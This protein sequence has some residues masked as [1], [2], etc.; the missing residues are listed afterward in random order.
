[1]QIIHDADMGTHLWYKLGG[2]AKYLLIASSR[3]DVQE[4]LDF[5]TENKIEK[6]F[7]CG[8][9]ANLIFTDDYFDGAVLQIRTGN[10]RLYDEI[11]LSRKVP[12]AHIKKSDTTLTVFG[13]EILDNL[14]V[15]SLQHNLTGLEWAG[16][17]PGTVGAGIRGNVGCFGGE[18]KDSVVDVEVIDFS[19]KDFQ[20]KKL[21]REELNFSYR[22]SLVKLHSNMI[23]L[24]ATF[25]LHNGING[26]LEKAKQTYFGNI[27]Y[28]KTR[29][30]L[31][32]PNCGSVFKN[33][34]KKDEVAKVLEVWPDA[35]EKIE[36]K[37]YGKVAMGY[38]I[39]KLGFAGETVGKAQIS[40]KHGNYILNLGG[41][42]AKDVTTL[43]H[44][45]QEKCQKTFGFTPEVEVEIIK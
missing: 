26:E 11:S 40:E 38:I 41:A 16:G 22:S 2:K 15:Y 27:M 39:H 45:I 14:V 1:M 43:I 13:G 34:V 3:Q 31:D 30:P 10:N 21:T 19:E 44:K 5:I 8:L 23:I 33:I 7:V 17:L 24:S 36:K 29:H 9:G 4:A 18:I 35:K 6:I 28:R 12:D 32:H 20:I 42:S 25:R 37:W